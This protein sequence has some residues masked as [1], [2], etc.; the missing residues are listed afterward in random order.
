MGNCHHQMGLWARLWGPVFLISNYV[1][2]PSPLRAVPSLS[3]WA[4]AVQWSWQGA[5]KGVQWSNVPHGFCFSSCLQ[6][7]ALASLRD[8]LEFGNQI[9]PC[10]LQAGFGR[11]LSWQQSSRI[12]EIKVSVKD[13]RKRK[14][15][16]FSELEFRKAARLKHG[17]SCVSSCTGEG[18]SGSYIISLWGKLFL[19]FNLFSIVFLIVPNAETLSFS[20][21]CCGDPQIVKLVLLLLC[22]C[23]LATIMNCKYV[24]GGMSD[25]QPLWRSWPTGWELLLWQV[26]R[27]I[28]FV[29]LTTREVTDR[30]SWI[31]F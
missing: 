12:R 22:N 2:R 26:F 20:S 28:S 27:W 4:P 18:T 29:R 31:N 11:R 16:T 30:P 24:I 14:I 19:H 7:P 3:R 23:N 25:R 17:R 5:L 9:N 15:I 13:R 1:V 10:P 6:V 21:S 8:A